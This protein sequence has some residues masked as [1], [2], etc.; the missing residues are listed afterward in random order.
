MPHTIAQ[1]DIVAHL[2]KQWAEGRVPHALLL[3]GPEGSGKMALAL[4]FARLL[5]CQN[6]QKGEMAEPCG[7]CHGCAMTRTLAHPDLH[8]AYPIIRPK[9]MSASG[10]LVCDVWLKE[11][12]DMLLQSPYFDL[13]AWEHRMGIEN[14]QPLI[15][16]E[17]SD[18]LLRKV[19][20]V[21]SQGGYKVVIIWLP[22]L[23][24]TT[25]SNKILKLLEEPPQQTLF[26]LCS[27]EPQRLLPTI[28]SR[29]QRIEVKGLS[30]QDIAAALV[31][32]R[33]LAPEDA[34]HTA[35][36]AAGSYTRALRQLSVNDDERE[37][38]DMFVLLMRKCYL[39]DI[40]EMHAWS[41]RVAAWG[42]ERQKSFLDYAQRLVRENFIYNFRQPELNYL[43]RE[44]ANFSTNFARFINERNVIP[45]SDELAAAQRDIEQNVNAR[46]V[47]FD[48]ALKMIVLLIQ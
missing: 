34:A 47:F 4:D 11:W 44:E 9:S 24:H 18:E 41:E 25:C 15:Y 31:Q 40:K 36:L 43:S 22:E 17:E 1:H 5:L 16:S 35:H 10:R 33:G 21:S 3:A 39:R 13:A 8:F 28:L 32:Q 2:Q 12:R 26:I 37:Y 20:L 6:P 19:S 45:I 48:F 38:F 29:T 46:M 7:T 14:Q 42:R 30:E 27:N 23:M